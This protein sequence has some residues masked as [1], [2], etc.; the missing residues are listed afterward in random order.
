MTTVRIFL[1]FHFRGFGNTLLSLVVSSARLP[2]S[3]KVNRGILGDGRAAAILWRNT[4]RPQGLRCVSNNL[5]N[6]YGTC[7]YGARALRHAPK[8]PFKWSLDNQQEGKLAALTSSYQ[9]EGKLAAL[10]SSYK[11]EGKLA[12]LTSSYQQEGKLHSQAVISRK[13]SCTHKQ[14]SAGGKASYTQK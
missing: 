7:S 3:D 14:L 2:F 11:Q 1:Q 12:A 6:T 10:K 13:E 4:T 9:Q 5:Y 8:L